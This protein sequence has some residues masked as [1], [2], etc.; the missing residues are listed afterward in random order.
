MHI[1][2]PH[3]CPVSQIYDTMSIVHVTVQSIH[4]MP[5]NGSTYGALSPKLNIKSNLRW[6]VLLCALCEKDQINDSSLILLTTFQTRFT[7]RRNLSGDLH[8]NKCVHLLKIYLILIDR[9]TT[10]GTAMQV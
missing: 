4:S 2:E 6:D 5:P 1:S 10:A 7:F 3:L 8:Y 9:Y